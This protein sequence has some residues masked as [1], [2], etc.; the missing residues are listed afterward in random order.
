[1]FDLIESIVK[2]YAKIDFPMSKYDFEIEL[3]KTNKNKNDV[4]MFQK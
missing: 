3:Y 1:M 4:H 2:C